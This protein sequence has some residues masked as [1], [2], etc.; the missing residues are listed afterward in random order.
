MLR[1]DL[2]SS[3]G[4]GCLPQN[5]SLEL[6]A[7]QRMLHAHEAIRRGYGQRCQVRQLQC[8]LR[9]GAGSAVSP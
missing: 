8:I 3:C 6:G 1:C 5:S 2:T 9:A 7:L 4:V